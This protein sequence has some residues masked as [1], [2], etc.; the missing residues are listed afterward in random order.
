MSFIKVL[1]QEDPFEIKAAIDWDRVTKGIDC[2]GKEYKITKLSPV[3][4][5]TE[6]TGKVREI[7]TFLAVRL[8]DLYYESGHRISKMK[9]YN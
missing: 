9:D 5:Q 7:P 8:L 1:K 3:E 4:L 6:R 2:N